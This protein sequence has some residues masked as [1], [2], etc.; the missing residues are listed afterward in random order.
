MPGPRG[1]QGQ[2]GLPGPPV[3]SFSHHLQF[4]ETGIQSGI[5]AYLKILYIIQAL[6]SKQCPSL[7]FTVLRSP[8][9]DDHSEHMEAAPR[10]SFYDSMTWADFASRLLLCRP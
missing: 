7:L 2:P 10:T 6:R 4:P 9:V 3:S 5:E 8:A 1:P